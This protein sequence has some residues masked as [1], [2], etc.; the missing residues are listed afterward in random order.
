[1]I[2]GDRKE[3]WFVKIETF[4]FK[5]AYGS[6]K[7]TQGFHPEQRFPAPLAVALLRSQIENSSI[8]N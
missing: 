5:T 4:Q 1:M 7:V 6:W 8:L 2:H 3:L